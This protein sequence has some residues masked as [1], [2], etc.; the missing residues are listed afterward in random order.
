MLNI[1]KWSETNR[2]TKKKILDRA[3]FDISVIREYVA[4]WIEIIKKEGDDGIV[5]YI[6]KFDNKSFTLK[7][8]KVSKADIENAYK[9]VNPKVV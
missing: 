6:R 8:L 3:M 4:K 5:K 9:R 1:Y 7:D 2:K